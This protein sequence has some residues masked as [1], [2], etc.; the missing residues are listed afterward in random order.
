V[1][2]DGVPRCW[3]C[4]GGNSR[5]QIRPK[6]SRRTGELRAAMTLSMSLNRPPYIH[7]V[8]I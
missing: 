1:G 2:A 5:S 4:L 8:S 6:I 7:S 3:W